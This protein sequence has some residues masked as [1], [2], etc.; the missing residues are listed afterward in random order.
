MYRRYFVLLAAVVS[1]ISGPLALAGGQKGEG[2]RSQRKARTAPDQSV[3]TPIDE[4]ERMSPEEQKQALSR[5][6][7][8]Q[9]Q[10]LEQRLRQFN[11]LPPEQR[12]ALSS[13]YGRLHQ[14]PAQQ[15][16]SVRKA[17]D[18]F[19]ML[20]PD[21]QQA[22]RDRLRSLAELPA[23]DRTAQLTSGGFRRDL[24]RKE[25]GMVRDMLPLLI[26]N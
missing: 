21:R 17:I 11:E 23:R 5:L 20:P 12:Q 14:L 26:P 24:S 18:R 3:K 13:L 7:P 22:I 1:V 10:R 2:H 15:Q 9:R 6:P 4:F 8:A 25:Q 19:S 16:E